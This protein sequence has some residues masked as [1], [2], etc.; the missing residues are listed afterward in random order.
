MLWA[1]R[2][3]RSGQPVRDTRDDRI[4][5]HYRYTILFS[6]HADLGRTLVLG[7]IGTAYSLSRISDV[8][9]ALHLR[10]I[11]RSLILVVLSWV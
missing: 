6:C 7:Y 5:A 9:L 4:D 1:D 8:R 10:S 11:A 2:S 3:D